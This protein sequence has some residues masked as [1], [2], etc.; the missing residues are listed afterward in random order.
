MIAYLEYVIYVL[1]VK[2]DMLKSVFSKE[3]CLKRMKIGKKFLVFIVALML[4]VASAYAA[5]TIYWHRQVS[6]NFSVVGISA[7]LLQLGYENYRSKVVAT[8]LDAN[9]Q[10][11][12]TI[13][14][15]N[16]NAI[17]L[18]TTFTTNAT[19]LIMN[20]TGQYLRYY[21]GSGYGVV[22]TVGAPFDISGYHEVDKLSM[23]WKDPGYQ[24]G[25]PIGYGLLVTIVPWA[26][27][28]TVPGYY[29]AQ[30]SFDMGF[31]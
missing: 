27:Y 21:W 18:N 7:E 16:F 1:R 5:T 20:C 30:V 13:Y 10:A 24:S 15:E 8:S 9:H 29:E 22:E 31:V 4:A 12:I 19:G 3:R 28:V 14:S 26:E 6:V 2:C 11:V 25:G 23:M 17:W